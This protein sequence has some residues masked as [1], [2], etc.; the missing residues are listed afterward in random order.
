MADKLLPDLAALLQLLDREER[1]LIAGFK[2][3]FESLRPSGKPVRL[4]LKS[5]DWELIGTGGE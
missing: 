4:I 5:G 2:G 3:T 1:V